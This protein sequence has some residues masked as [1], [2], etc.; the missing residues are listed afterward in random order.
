MSDKRLGRQT[1]VISVVLP[2]TQSLGTEAVEIYNR[3]R[4]T[5][6]PWQEL[7]LEDIMALDC[8]GLWT[9]MKFGWSV[10]R[11]N[12]KSEL[13]IIRAVWGVSHGRRVLYT[14]HRT[15]TSHSAY[16]KCVDRLSEA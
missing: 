9:H 12:G 4:R 6:Q 11:R 15:T 10:P 7:M 14:A 16:E 5:A 3:S 2:Y 13:L 1:P 8:D